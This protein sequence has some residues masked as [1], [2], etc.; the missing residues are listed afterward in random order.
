M[1]Y[2]KHRRQGSILF[3]QWMGIHKR[4]STETVIKGDVGKEGILV[5]SWN[6]ISQQIKSF[7]VCRR[8]RRWDHDQAIC[9]KTLCSNWHFMP[10]FQCTATSAGHLSVAQGQTCL[11][12]TL[13]ISYTSHKHYFF[14]RMT[15]PRL[16]VLHG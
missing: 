14:K 9:G 13:A 11:C 4:E 12:M 5:F 7:P 6:F 8:C 15:W 3:W 1:L 16:I 10:L 2:C